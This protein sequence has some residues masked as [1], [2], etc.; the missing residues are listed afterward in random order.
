MAGRYG[1][2]VIGV[3]F[4]EKVHIPGFQEHPR[5][6]VVAVAAQRAARAEEVAEAWEIPFSTDD[7]KKLVAHPD[8]DI[9]AIA[10][11]PHLHAPMAEATIAAGKPFLI[12]KPLAHTL[13]AAK[14]IAAGAADA[15]IPAIID[16]EFRFVPAWMLMQR[17][18]AGGYVGRPRFVSVSWLVDILADPEARR[19]G[20]ASQQESGGGTLGAF[21][22]HVFD[23]LGWFFGEISAAAGFLATGVPRRLLPDSK[24]RA[25]VTADDTFGAHLRFASGLL[26]A[27]EVCAVGWH[28]GGHRIT[29]Y[30]DDG[31]LELRQESPADYIHGARLLAGRAGDPM[32]EEMPLPDDLLLPREYPDGRLGPFVQAID[33]L[34]RAIEKASRPGDPDLS[35]GLRAQA[36]MD[37]VS[38]ASARENWVSTD[39]GPPGARRR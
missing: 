36:V 26:A 25:E 22:S 4:G 11:P 15:G 27:V 37:A 10:T 9:V 29:V 21:G 38:R 24:S 5:T 7:Y 35:A 12:E 30:G 16:F 33:A 8:V 20:W 23:Y 28:R 31:T 6:K 18:L 19:F 17:E 14:D 13:Q 1:V 39:A 2:G 34:V 3:G 32:L